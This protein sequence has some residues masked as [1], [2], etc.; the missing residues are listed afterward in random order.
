MQFFNISD[1]FMLEKGL[2]CFF[3]FP[4]CNMLFT[5]TIHALE[6]LWFLIGGLV[7]FSFVS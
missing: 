4:I 1:S 5:V 2:V 7:L 3:M 6:V